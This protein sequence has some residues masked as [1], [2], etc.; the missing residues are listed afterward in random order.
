MEM[1]P[2]CFLEAAMAVCSYIIEIF[3]D[4]PP[5][6][7]S[8]SWMLKNFDLFSKLWVCGVT[9]IIGNRSFTCSITLF[10]HVC[11]I[12][13]NLQI[14]RLKVCS[15]NRRTGIDSLIFLENPLLLDQVYDII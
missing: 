7:R 5:R 8:H 6:G 2:S 14:N 1:L 12:I 3:L 11:S 10:S 15:Y 4:V 9:K 13:G